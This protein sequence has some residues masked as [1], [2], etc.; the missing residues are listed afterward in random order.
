MTDEQV[1]QVF[2]KMRGALGEKASAEMSDALKQARKLTTSKGKRE[3]P[4]AKPVD[5]EVRKKYDRELNAIEDELEKI[6][7]DPLGVWQELITNPESFNEGE[8]PNKLADG[9]E[10]S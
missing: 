2:A 4:R 7:N 8:D 6:Y 9:E 1:E 3:M 10:F 5:N